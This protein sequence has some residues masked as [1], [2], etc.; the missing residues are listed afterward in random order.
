MHG[1]MRYDIV[2]P[3]PTRRRT[4]THRKHQP[5]TSDHDLR[6]H[7]IGIAIFGLLWVAIGCVVGHM[8]RVGDGTRT[9]GPHW[10]P[11]SNIP[12]REFVREVRD[13]I[14]V[15]TGTTTPSQ[16]AAALQRGLGRPARTM[17]V[18]VSSGIINFGVNIGGRHTDGVIYIMLR[19]ST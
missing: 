15:A 4:T 7:W 2:P 3:P 19:L 9:I 6:G 13:W 18:R 11:A 10:D 5:R 16:Q 12:F 17:A 1:T 14:N 8:Q